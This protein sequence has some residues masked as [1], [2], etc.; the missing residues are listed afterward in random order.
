MLQIKA[1]DRI[2]ENIDASS[3]LLRFFL[4]DVIENIAST[5]CLLNVVFGGMGMQTLVAKSAE[6]NTCE[7]RQIAM[8]YA[9]DGFVVC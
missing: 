3:N 5:L 8:Q 1:Y 2:R 4:N 6:C 7:Y 9:Y